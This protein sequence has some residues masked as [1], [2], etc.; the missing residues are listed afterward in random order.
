MPRRI[1]S[2]EVAG[3][4]FQESVDAAHEV[5]IVVEQRGGLLGGNPVEELQRADPRLHLFRGSDGLG[6]LSVVAG[7]RL[8]PSGVNDRRNDGQ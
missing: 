1:P 2:T 6:D 8:S 4:P 7:C 5:E 3:I